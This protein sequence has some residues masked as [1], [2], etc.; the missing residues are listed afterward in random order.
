M[1]VDLIFFKSGHG[2]RRDDLHKTGPQCVHV[3]LPS[4]SGVSKRAVRNLS[5]LAAC[6]TKGYLKS[7]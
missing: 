6:G 5:N 1:L 7:C 4:N 3:W 2:G